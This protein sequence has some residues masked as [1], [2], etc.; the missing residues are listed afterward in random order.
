MLPRPGEHQKNHDCDCHREQQV[1]GEVRPKHTEEIPREP[2]GFIVSRK[3][4][5]VT[6][7][8]P[9][10]AQ[11]PTTISMLLALGIRL[12]HV[13]NDGLPTVIDVDV[14]DMNSCERAGRSAR[15]LSGLSRQKA[16]VTA[17]TPGELAPARM[18]TCSSHQADVD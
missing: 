6:S 18:L 11:V 7:G 16:N 4:R 14:L 15:C 9:L 10:G 13:A 3:S 8:S 17:V 5:T 12:F 1:V 2:G